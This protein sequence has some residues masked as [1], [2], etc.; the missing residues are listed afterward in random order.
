MKL[1]LKSTLSASNQCSELSRVLSCI[2]IADGQKWTSDGAFHDGRPEE[3]SRAGRHEVQTDAGAAGA[4][5]EQ[6]DARRVSAERR[7]VIVN[8]AQRQLLVEQT[9][10]AR[11]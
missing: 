10:V 2:C 11:S 7:D 8:P 1:S 3:G 6:R 9:D 5:A 4:L